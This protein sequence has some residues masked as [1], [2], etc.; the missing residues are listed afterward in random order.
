M[1]DKLTL[2]ELQLFIR[3]SLYTSL[4]GFYWVT[5]E[6]SEI[7]E[8]YAG[9]CYLELVEK[10]PD[11]VNVRAKAK[12]II[13][14]NRLRFIKPLFEN[15]TGDT[16]RPGIK[17]L[18]QIKIE[19]HEIYGL[20]LLINSIDPAFTL[21]EMAMKRQQI[22]RKLE[23]EGIINMNK[24]LEFP[25]IPQKIAIISSAGAAGY[26][27]FIKHLKNNNYGYCFYTALF[28]AVLQ[29]NEAEQSI[30][31]AFDRI[32]KNIDL[33]DAVVIVRGGGSQTDLSWFDNYAIAYHI[34][35]FPLPVI[36]GIGHEKDLSVTDMVAFRSE[37]TPTA[38]ADFLVGSVLEAEQ[39]LMSIS[40]GI[41]SLA[42]DTINEFKEKLNTIIIRL[43]PGSKI[44]VTSEKEKL[45]TLIISLVSYGKDFLNREKYQL[46]QK[47]SDIRT[48]AKSVLS[49]NKSLIGE[50][51]S[52]L[53]SKSQRL[54]SQTSLKIINLNNSLGLLNPFNVLRRGYTI[55]SAKGRI[56]K[57][58]GEISGGDAIETLF[59]D[60]RVTSE[61]KRENND[62][63]K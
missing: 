56:L 32:A 46:S 63:R 54:I 11:E 60:G 61:V 20:S 59:H 50:S 25:A 13:W 14:A 41:S 51:S 37:K 44:H 4:P 55:T 31:S 62:D 29:G 23:E 21:G 19:Y 26:T 42:L 1:N 49:S 7:R 17:V 3:D 36:T 30:I 57:S 34:T 12:G 2:T 39:N 5:A 28:E 43:I 38:V 16:L 6:I 8:N 27:D 35:Q 24:E 9:H 10:H 47:G 52:G 45:G 33:F 58:A 53:E 18:I 48:G 40:S 22:I 15:V